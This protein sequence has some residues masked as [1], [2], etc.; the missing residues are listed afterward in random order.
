MYLDGELRQVSD[1]DF[2]R[3]HLDEVMTVDY[4]KLQ[5]CRGLEEIYIRR[6]IPTKMSTDKTAT[7]K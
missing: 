5:D 6:G 2:E 7:G 1:G 4:D 3:H